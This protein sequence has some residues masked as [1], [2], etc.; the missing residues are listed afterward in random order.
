MSESINGR[1]VCSAPVRNQSKLTRLFRAEL[2]ILN[3]QS[4]QQQQRDDNLRSPLMSAVHANCGF[5]LHGVR[6]S[7]FSAFNQSSSNNLRL[8][9]LHS[10]PP[11]VRN[12]CELRMVV[13]K[14]DLTSNKDRHNGLLLFEGGT[15]PNINPPDWA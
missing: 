13:A 15:H 7:R 5:A 14:K 1:E 4:E 3:I 9:N 8:A 6:S 2:E 11:S 12:T 10:C